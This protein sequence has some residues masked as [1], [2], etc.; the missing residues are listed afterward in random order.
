MK[1]I[2][3]FSVFIALL[4]VIISFYSCEQFKFDLG[5]WFDYNTSVVRVI[6]QDIPYIDD[7]GYY[8]ISNENKTINFSLYNKY[9]FELATDNVE[10]TN[11][12]PPLHIPLH[13]VLI[14]SRLF[15][16]LQVI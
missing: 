3:K 6:N 10:M 15:L 12:T 11:V 8:C 1:K 9:D 4:F 13:K 5:G 16:N 2:I 7:N 14:K